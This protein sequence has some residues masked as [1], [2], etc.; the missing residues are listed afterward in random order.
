MKKIANQVYFTRT[1]NMTAVA[2]KY[3][4]NIINKRIETISNF[5]NLIKRM[6]II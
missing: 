3:I 4:I 1:K 2:K 6:D 5:T